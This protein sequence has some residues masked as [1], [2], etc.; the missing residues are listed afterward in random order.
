MKWIQKFFRLAV[1]EKWLFA[2][3]LL[4][5]C[6]A[7]VLLW[8]VPLQQCLRLMPVRGPFTRQPT[9]KELTRLKKAIHRTNYLMLWKNKCLVMSIASRWMLQRRHIASALSLGVGFDAN[10]K[11]IAHA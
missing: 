6:V 9:R 10:G 8:F 4:F 11:L 7:K 2:E 3:A 5:V 1:A